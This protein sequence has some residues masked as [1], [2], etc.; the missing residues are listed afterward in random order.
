MSPQYRRPVSQ[1]LTLGETGA[2]ANWNPDTWKEYS[3]FRFDNNHVS[4]LIAILADDSLLAIDG[5]EAMA[6]VH[7]WR[8]LAELQAVEALPSLIELLNQIDDNDD[9]WVASELPIVFAKIGGASLDVLEPFAIDD[10]NG[11]FAR[12]CAYRSVAEIGNKHPASRSRCVEILVTMLHAYEA[13]ERH[14]N[15]FLISSLADLKAL[16][17]FDLVREVYEKDRVD[18]D[19]TGDL[20]DAEIEFGIRTHRT[21]SRKLGEMHER[22]SKF[23][24][25]EGSLTSLKPIIASTKVGRNDPCPCE[26]GK[27]Y[28]KCCGFAITLL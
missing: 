13:N 8:I 10:G 22:F 20:E 24:D 11:P 9:D 27:K 19:V 6:P 1:L 16:E 7:A 4:D 28:K 12:I 3:Q 5:P 25:G 2:R 26:S 23:F 17:S 21:T 14:L 15:A 18:L